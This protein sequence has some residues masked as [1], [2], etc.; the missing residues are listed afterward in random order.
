MAIAISGLIAIGLV[1]PTSIK[2]LAGIYAFG[3]TLAITIAHLSIIRLRV[4]DPDRAAAVSNSLEPELARIKPPGSGHRRRFDQ[5]PWPFS[6]CSP[7]TTSPAGSGLAWMAFGLV[8][9]V[10]YRK[11]FEGTTLTKR[12]SVTEQALTKQM[13]EVAFR[14]ILVPVFGTELDDDIVATAGRLAAAEQEEDRRRG[15][16]LAPRPRLRG[17]G[18]ADPAA[19]R[20]LA[21]RSARRKRAGLWQGQTRSARSTRMSRSAPR[22][23]AL[24]ASA[25]GS[26]RRRGGAGLKRSSSGVSRR[27]RSKAARRLAGSVSTKPAEI[28]AATEYVLKKAPCRVLLTAPPEALVEPTAQATAAD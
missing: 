5:R 26:S 27:P 24:A 1:A 18:A 6:A 21:R 22:S 9:Y 3:A 12:V 20:E 8:F 25:P 7:T 16:W 28:G 10:I 19:G 13:P 11:V 23:S 2:L 17:R 14:N 4:T 15:R